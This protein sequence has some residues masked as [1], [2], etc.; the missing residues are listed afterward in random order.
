MDPAIPPPG[1]PAEALGEGAAERRPA[2]ALRGRDRGLAAQQPPAVAPARGDPEDAMSS[3]KITLFYAMLIAVASLAVGMVL[4]SRLDLSPESSAQTIAVPPMN[5]APLSGPVDATTF[6]TIAKN[7]SPF[8]VNIRTESKRRATDMSE[9]FGGEDPFRRFFGLPQGPGGG[10]PRDQVVQ[11]AGTGFVISKEGLILTNNHVVE[12]ATEILVAFGEN[13]YD[14]EE[15][16]A[17]LV[18]RDQLTDSALIELIEKPDRP[19]VEAKFGDSSQMQTGDWVMAI[20]NPFALAHTVTVGVISATKRPFQ[21]ADQRS[22]DVLQTDAAIN[23]GN[24]GGPLLNIRGEVIA[25]NTAILANSRSEGN[26]GIG[27]AIPINIV[28]DLLPQLRAGK[29]IRGRIGVS[30]QDVPRDNLAEF[31]LK[32]RSGALVVQVPKDGPAAKAGVEPGDVILEVNGKP[33]PNRDELIRLITGTKPGT[34]VPVKLLREKKEM[35]VNITVEELDLEVESGTLQG[36][37]PGPEEEGAGFGLTLG[38]LTSSMSRS[39]RLPPDTT[40]AVIMDIE[41]GSP[42]EDAGLVQGD[43]LL[44]VNNQ[45]VSSAAEASRILQRIPSGGRAMLLVWKSR[46]G[47]ELFLTLRKD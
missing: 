40:G 8:V 41:P 11:S 36:Q 3:R 47:Q 29:V 27:F 19:L 4:A 5:S 43:V 13:Q 14:Q 18:G 21:V 15:Y 1:L 44:K 30:V 6:R 17:K 33:I 22:Q 24:S 42:A 37:G 34:T 25:I 32:Q 10:R 16:K 35:T 12:G 23:P 38:N 46:Q 9:F 26:I 39:L 28:R 31:G 45:A 7:A 2:W 20:G